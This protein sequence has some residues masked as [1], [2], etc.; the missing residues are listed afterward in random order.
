NVRWRDPLQGRAGRVGQG[1]APADNDANRRPRAAPADN[2]H[3]SRHYKNDSMTVWILVL[4]LVLFAL[5]V[6]L[7]L[8]GLR[9]RR[10]DDHPI[11]RRCGFDLVGRPQGSDRCPE[12]GAD[13]N[14]PHGI[15][16]GRRVRRTGMLATGTFLTG[17]ILA[18]AGVGAWMALSDTD[19][20]QYAPAWYLRREASGNDPKS[21]DAAL[22]ELDKRLVAG[23]LPQ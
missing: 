9:G 21:R 12:C 14:R 23:V 8:R 1:R 15:R 17:M 3:G 13:L 18:F 10:V 4:P 19:L 6:F 20:R 7:I 22:A 11:C 5:G 2:N 16:D